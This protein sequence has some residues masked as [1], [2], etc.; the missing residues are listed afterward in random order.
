MNR[1]TFLAVAGAVTTGIGGCV[2][3]PAGGVGGTPS[4]TDTATGS[5]PIPTRTGSATPTPDPS[6]PLAERGKPADI[7]SK[8]ILP[9]GIVAIDEL[10]FAPDWSGHDTEDYG[11]DLTDEAMVI[12]L[13]REGSARAY[14]IRVLW[15]HEVVNENFGGPILV[16][17]CPLCASGLVADRRVAGEPASFGVSG[18]LWRPPG[19]ETQAS[20]DA[21]GIFGAS[22]D[23]RESTPRP[24][25]DHNLVMYDEPTGS[26][27]SQLLAQAI[28]GPRTG[29]RLPFLPSTVAPWG[30]WQADHPDT[31]VLLP[32]PHSTA[33]NPPIPD[34][35]GGNG[36]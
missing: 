22:L 31:A 1:R 20:R 10:A 3:N 32:L 7:C 8:E 14:P 19:A 25:R 26:Y 23:E 11:G 36:E 17:F 33:R 15:K 4:A 16:T 24:A 30:D 2:S 27:W 6:L 34:T 21:D 18:R 9:V 35:P 12:G 29:D 5:K 28:C 13:E